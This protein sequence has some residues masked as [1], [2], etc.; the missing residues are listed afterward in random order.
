[1]S[2]STGTQR[3]GEVDAKVSIVQICGEPELTSLIS[4]RRCLK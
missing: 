1:M 2:V 3:E 4:W